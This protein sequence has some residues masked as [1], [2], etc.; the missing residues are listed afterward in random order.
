MIPINGGSSEVDGSTPL[1][2]SSSIIFIALS[3]A[4]LLSTFLAK[5]FGIAFAVGGCSSPS[6]PSRDLDRVVAPPA[7]RS[8]A[9]AKP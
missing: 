9:V 7:P 4:T 3:I 2:R 1:K 6:E 8:S 5:G